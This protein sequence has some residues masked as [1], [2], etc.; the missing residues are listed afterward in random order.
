MD[1]NHLFLFILVP[2]NKVAS[3]KYGHMADFT[4]GL[5]IFVES[6]REKEESLVPLATQIDGL[7][8]QLDELEAI[9]QQLDE[10]SKRL[11]NR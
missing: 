4:S 10:Y 5:A 9:V 8:G 1:F 11:E 7:E 2:K 6:L 3:E